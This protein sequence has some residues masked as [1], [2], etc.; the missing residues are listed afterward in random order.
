VELLNSS[1]LEILN[2]DS[3]PTFCSG[4]RLEVID[5]PLG[6]FGLLESI[7]NWEVSSEPS[8]LEHRL[9]T[10]QVSVPVRLISNPRSTKWGSFERA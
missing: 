1:N 4:G 6:S 10:L 7:T 3:K 9:F 5:I 2:Q 8:L